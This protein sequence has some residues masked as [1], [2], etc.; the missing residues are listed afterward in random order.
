MGAA[1]YDRYPPWVRVLA[2]P[3][4]IL[5]T[6]LPLL[7]GAMLMWGAFGAIAFGY[8]AAMVVVI[9]LLLL[10]FQVGAVALAWAMWALNRLLW[11]SVA[12]LVAASPL[13]L[14]ASATGR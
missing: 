2:L 8:D 14:L 9:G 7:A 3:F 4:L 1:K 12:L 5:V 10:A 13:L 11:M 6:P